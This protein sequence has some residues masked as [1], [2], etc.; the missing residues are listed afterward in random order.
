[1][2]SEQLPTIQVFEESQANF[3]RQRRLAEPGT[4]WMAYA[5]VAALCRCTLSQQ[6][7]RYAQVAANAMI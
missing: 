1:M 5:T 3:W 6:I 2:K 7:G 4:T